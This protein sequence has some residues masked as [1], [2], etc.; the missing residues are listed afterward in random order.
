V[1]PSDS[2]HQYDPKTQMTSTLYPGA[3]AVALVCTLHVPSDRATAIAPCSADTEGSLDRCGSADVPIANAVGGLTIQCP[4][5]VQVSCGDSTDPSDTGTATVNGACDDPAVAYHDEITFT[6]CPTDLLLYEIQRTW[7][8]TDSCGGSASCEQKIEV[9]KD[10]LVLDMHPQSCPN[11]VNTNGNG[12]IPAAILGTAGFDVHDIDWSTVQLWGRH[13]N[14]GPVT[15]THHAYEDVATPYTGIDKCG[16]NTLHG[17]GYTDLTLKFDKQQV[18][19]ALNLTSYPKFAFVHVKV[20]GQL[21]NGC[22]FT[23]SDCIRVQ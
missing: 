8:A 14:G 21:T 22:S 16:C 9:Q 2:Q 15:P 3:I 20:V 23:S 18:V 19:S 7:T 4:G 17:D 12:V 11:P 13:C 5:A 6:V 10:V 1:P